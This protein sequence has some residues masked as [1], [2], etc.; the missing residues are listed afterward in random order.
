MLFDTFKDVMSGRMGATKAEAMHE[1]VD[2]IPDCTCN[3]CKVGVEKS[4]E[5]WNK[6]EGTRKIEQKLLITSCCQHPEKKVFGPIGNVEGLDNIH[7]YSCCV[8]DGPLCGPRQGCS[9]E[10]CLDCNTTVEERKTYKPCSFQCPRQDY[11]CDEFYK[12][13]QGHYGL[14]CYK[15]MKADGMYNDEDFCFDVLINKLQADNPKYRNLLM[16]FR[17]SGNYGIAHESR[18]M[19]YFGEDKLKYLVEY[20]DF[21]P[22]LA[23][24]FANHVSALLCYAD[25]DSEDDEDV[26]APNVV[27]FHGAL[28]KTL[29]SMRHTPK[30]RPW[31][32]LKI[33]ARLSIIF[34]RYQHDY[35]NPDIGKFVVQAAAKF[36]IQTKKRKLIN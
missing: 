13:N 14:I 4:I 22:K 10:V 35:Y 34:K 31:K 1:L 8:C 29:H 28:S 19:L 18:E 5:W 30:I 33:L 21:L 32:V 2:L 20:R 25:S 15:C 23:I 24:N 7:S 11:S 26:H 6:Q 16:F 17:Y 27:A 36:R 12:R 3:D 9:A